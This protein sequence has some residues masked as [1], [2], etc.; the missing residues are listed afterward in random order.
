[1]GGVVSDDASVSPLRYSFLVVDDEVSIREGLTEALSDEQTTVYTASGG[2]EAA[3][4]LEE[5]DID[6]VLLDQKLKVTGEDG[7]KLLREFKEKYPEVIFIIMTAYG[8]FDDAVNAIKLGC[9]DYKAK[10]LDIHQLRL[11]IQNA[12]ASAALRKEVEILRRNQ[13]LSSG[14][15]I[16]GPSPKT[17]DVL[18]NVKKVARSG[19]ATVLLRGETG[20]GKEVIARK[21]HEHSPVSGGPFVAVNCSNFDENLL[22]SELFGHE[23]GAFTDAR[24]PKKGLLELADGGTMFLDE[25]GDMSPKLQSKLLRVLETKT[26]RRV[27]GITDIRVKMRFLAATNKDLFK[28]VQENRFRD[29]LYYRLTVVP[30]HIHALRDR[31]EDIPDLAKHFLYFYTRDL[32]KSI[33]GFSPE[34]LQTLEEYDW[35]GNVRELKNLME[36]LA[37]MTEGPLIDVEDLPANIISNSRGPRSADSDESLFSDGRV[38]SLKEVE[39]TAIQHAM[40]QC[41]GNKTRAADILGISRQT[42]RTKLREYELEEIPEES[43]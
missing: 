1:M 28:E 32:G 17:R 20:V 7:L 11:T 34:A 18:E 36:N 21:I 10:P 8:R 16:F 24:E 43:P 3:Q 2:H 15:I 35:P 33:Q 12:L 6:L 41:G 29:D 27:G 23:K 30:I 37:L 25:I 5:K 9:F 39:K 4:I 13:E 14:T 40:H 22:E 26:F 19:T 31:K 42:L 38:P